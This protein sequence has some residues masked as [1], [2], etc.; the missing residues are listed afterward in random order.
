MK[1]LLLAPLLMSC[2]NSPT[3]STPE[4]EQEW[5]NENLRKESITRKWSTLS[6][7]DNIFITIKDLHHYW[8]EF[9]VYDSR[10]KSSYKTNPSKLR[11]SDDDLYTIRSIVYIDKR[12]I[13]FSLDSHI[14]ILSITVHLNYLK[15]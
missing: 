2:I 10:I 6:P 4:Q 11:I 12:N 15:G 13:E 9:E 3:E 5:V 7:F 1:L 8:Y 14:T